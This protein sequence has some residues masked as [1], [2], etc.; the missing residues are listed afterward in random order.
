MLSDIRDIDFNDLGGATP[1]ARIF[2]YAFVFVV[3][4]F[5]GT[6][7]FVKE[8]REQFERVK[9][10][11]LELRTE[12]ESKQQKAANLDNYK[13]QLVEMEDLLAAMLRQLPSKTEMDQLLVDVSQTALAAGID[14]RRFQPEAEVIHDFYAERPITIEMV[15]DYHQFGEFISG[16]AALPRVVV[17]TM[18]DLSLLDSQAQATAV[19]GGHLRLLGTVTTYRYLEDS[20]LEAQLAAPEGGP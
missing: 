9:A 6:W 10:Q 3:I 5:L 1:A 16:V 11:E 8:K 13:K 12:L 2:L 7:F 20:E 18:S 15:G 17:V 19:R 4:A 14:S